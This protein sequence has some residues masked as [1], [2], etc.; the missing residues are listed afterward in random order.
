MRCKPM[1][2]TLETPKF[3]VILQCPT[4]GYKT[5]EVKTNPLCPCCRNPLLTRYIIKRE[6]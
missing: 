6:R 2:K 1:P 5:E 3:T 4:C